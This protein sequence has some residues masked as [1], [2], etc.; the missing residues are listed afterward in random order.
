MVVAM[1]IGMSAEAASAQDPLS[2]QDLLTA[3]VVSTASKFQ[4]EVREA[5]AAITIV[6]AEEIRGFGHRTLADVLRSVRGLYT[7]YDRNYSYIGMRGFARPGDYNTR[8][9]MLLDGHRLNDPVY[10]MAPI[11]TDFPVDVSLID[12]V[13]VIRGPGSS[14]YGTNA[15]FAV[16]NVITKTGAMA[17]GVRLD[18][19]GGAMRTAGSTLSYGQVL[20]GNRELLLAASVCRS[21]GGRRLTFPEL[22]VTATDL[23]DDES[24]GVSGTFSVG[25]FSLRGGYGD[26]TKQVPTAAYATV[27]GDDRFVTTD[28]RGF[29]AADYDGP[30]GRG[31]T[32]TAR[33]S[34][35]YYRFFGGYPLPLDTEQT[36]LW[37]D[38]AESQMATAE[39]TAR[40]R[41]GAAHLFTAGIELRRQLRNHMSAEDESGLQLD[42]DK[43]STI[44][45]VYVQDEMRV[46]PWMLV[47]AGARVDRYA[48]FG[49]HVAPRLAVVLLPRA[50]TSIKVLHGGAFRAPNPYELHYYAEMASRSLGPERIRSTEVVWEESISDRVRTVVTAFRYDV[51]DIVQLRS[52]DR[53]GSGDVLFFENAG[54]VRATGVEAEIETRLARGVS[55]RLSH[56]SARSRDEGAGFEPANSPRHLSKFGVMLPAGRMT[57]GIEGHYVSGRSALDGQRLPGV[58]LPNLALTSP[59]GRRVELAAG[60][61]NVFDTSYADPGAEEHVQ[62]LIPQ[63]GRTAMLRVRVRF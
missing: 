33:V 34:Y 24:V 2:L 29:L 54:D 15:F 27:F 25:R 62:T 14:L 13:E 7:T 26:R 56:S 53:S 23:D 16:V 36:S 17:E 1:A 11:G 52:L 38:R 35:D 45:G 22:N 47:N 60:L 37:V 50:H 28:A 20:D 44:A 40:R 21:S 18:A 19:G 10:D 61:Y 46:T 3:E 9:L 49:S 48:G 42:V 63:D 51:T 41:L 6:T 5:P 43:P 58:F 8:I 55:A 59:V 39:L 31:W 57:V 30:V 4:Q 32:G 12:R